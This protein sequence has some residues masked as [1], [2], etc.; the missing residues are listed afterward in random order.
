MPHHPP[1]KIR[2]SIAK[3][4]FVWLL[5]ALLLM[6]IVSPFLENVETH[7]HFLSF[8]FIMLMLVAAWSVSPGVKARGIALILAIA[9]AGLFWMGTVGG[10]PELSSFSRGF[11][12]VYYV[13]IIAMILWHIITAREININILC[14]AA[15]AFILI[16]VAWAV[17]YWAISDINPNAFTPP[18]QSAIPEIKFHHYL[19]FSLIT[20][21][22][23]G[24]G[25]ITPVDHFAQMW[26]TLEAVCG[27]FYLAVLVA[28]LVSL[29]RR[30]R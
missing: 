7:H 5:A 20:L 30:K 15:S 23:V 28:R 14:G 18:D 16:G 11:L 13:F 21:T 4:G 1:K 9:S 3:Y 17:S 25:D 27:N 29:Y 6:W 19:Y 10:H 8:L 2:P 12:F 24:Y 22:S 26:A